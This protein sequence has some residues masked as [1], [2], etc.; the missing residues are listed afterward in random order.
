MQVVFVLVF[1]CSLAQ[2]CRRGE[3]VVTC[4]RFVRREFEGTRIMKIADVNAPRLDLTEFED[5]EQL[6]IV[7]SRLSCNAIE[8]NQGTIVILGSKECSHDV[9]TEET[10]STLTSTLTSLTRDVLSNGTY[11][12]LIVL[13]GVISAIFILTAVI[14]IALAL[15]RKCRGR[16]HAI[17]DAESLVYFDMSD[18]KVE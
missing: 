10:T 18:F 14:C 2:P 17:A 15:W 6:Q 16:T 12:K 1:S 7:K 5:L 9:T 4:F 8:R 13:Y 11:V 3:D